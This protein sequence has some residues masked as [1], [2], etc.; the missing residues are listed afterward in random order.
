MHCRQSCAVCDSQNSA[1]DSTEHNF[2]HLA[3]DGW[4]QV[5]CA[6]RS[7]DVTKSKLLQTNL[8]PSCSPENLLHWLECTPRCVPALK[9]HTASS[10]GPENS[11]SKQSP[12]HHAKPVGNC[13]GTCWSRCPR[14]TDGGVEA[15]KKTAVMFATSYRHDPAKSGGCVLWASP[16]ASLLKT[17]QYTEQS[18]R[19]VLGS[20][21]PLG[22]INRYQEIRVAC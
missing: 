2:N 19:C 21:S 20:L 12:V 22:I 4:T 10:I 15:I 9:S 14:I 11:A 13:L 7:F 18:S 5:E 16:H 3:R 8:A 6:I 1:P 17:P